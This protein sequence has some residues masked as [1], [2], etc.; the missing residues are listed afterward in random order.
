MDCAV[1]AKALR[2]I[3]VYDARV[4]GVQSVE[5]VASATGRSRTPPRIMFVAGGTRQDLGYF[6]QQFAGDWKQL[7]EFARNPAQPELRLDKPLTVRTVAAYLAF[8]VLLAIG[9]GMTLPL[10]ARP[11]DGTRSRR[12]SDL[13]MVRAA[14]PRCRFAASVG[15]RFGA[16][17][18]HGLGRAASLQRSMQTH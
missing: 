1:S 16:S 2:L 5:M 13:R 11:T 9:G 8:F 7:D 3:P 12:L 6:S 10:S 17:R 15:C 18:L 14:S 4:S